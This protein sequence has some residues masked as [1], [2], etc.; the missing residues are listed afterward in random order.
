MKTRQGR[1]GQSFLLSFLLVFVAGSAH[2]SLFGWL[3]PD[4]N[5]T[6]TQYPIVMVG[7]FLAFDDILGIDY[8][9]RIPEELRREGATVYPINL[10]AFNGSVERGEQLIRALE[11]RKALYGHARF[12]IVGH[13]GG[14]TTARYV[15]AMRP[16]L[17]ASVTSVHGG[18]KGL[19]FADWV[20]RTVPEGSALEGIG[21]SLFSALGSAVEWLAGHKPADYPQDVM[22]MLRDYTTEASLAFN[23]QYPQGV[24][25]SACGE[26]AYSVNGVR[27]YSWAGTGVLTNVLDPLDYFFVLSA[28]FY[29][30]DTD[31]LV[32]RCSSHLGQVIRDNYPMNHVDAMNHMFGLHSL[33]SPDPISLYRQ[34]ANRLK[35]AGL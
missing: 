32:G 31:G 9:Y 35:G 4:R 16:D 23:Q 30:D 28:S 10:S 33:F 22:A 26:G 20:R 24:P 7:G 27:Y 17:V 18:H 5:Y 12:N 21:A 6:R 8:F 25:T 11:E 15:A 19:A 2:A 3:F 14:A 13:S 1:F 34:H 29:R